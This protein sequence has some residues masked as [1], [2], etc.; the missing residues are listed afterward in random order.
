VSVDGKW[1]VSMTTQRG[2][3]DATLEL[4]SAGSDLSGTWGGAQGA[5]SF[6]GGKV[7]GNDVEWTV[8]TNNPMGAMA[9]VFK[10]TVD[11]D[12]ISG[13]VQL[14]QFGSG[15]FAGKRA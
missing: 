11:G 2:A 7:D 3:R 14:G 9:L 13:T 5:Q 8:N 6:S 1:N 12:S 4:V 15:T 10:G